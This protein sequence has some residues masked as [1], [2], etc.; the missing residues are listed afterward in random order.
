MHHFSPIYAMLHLFGRT[1]LIQLEGL[2]YYK[3]K[4]SFGYMLTLY[5]KFQLF[6]DLCLALVYK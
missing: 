6:I 2:I 4:K 1:R 3:K 5:H